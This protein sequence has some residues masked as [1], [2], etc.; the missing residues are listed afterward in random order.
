MT[1]F[2]RISPL[3]AAHRDQGEIPSPN[4]CVPQRHLTYPGP[5]IETIFYVEQDELTIAALST[6]PVQDPP[7]PTTRFPPPDGPRSLPI[8]RKRVACSCNTLIR[9]LRPCG[10]GCGG[11][12]NS[13]ARP[14]R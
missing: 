2:F 10:R 3:F 13:R 1:A 12:R 8:L 7:S 14:R 6:R 11:V 9:Q 5:D 4:R